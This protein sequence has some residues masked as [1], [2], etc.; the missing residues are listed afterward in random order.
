MNGRAPSASPETGPAAGVTLFAGQSAPPPDRH[1]V[2]QILRFARHARDNGFPVGIDESLDALRFAE[3]ADLMDQGEIRWGLRALFCASTADWERFDDLFDSFWIYRGQRT[4]VRVSGAA[5]R[6]GGDA[7]RPEAQRLGIE[8]GASGGDAGET[9]GGASAAE[10]LAGTDFRHLHDARDLEAVH[11][12]AERL[13]RRMRWRLSR[14]RRVRARGRVID[15]RNTIHK[16][17][18]HGGTPM[19]LAFKRRHPRPLKLVVILD[20]SG[21]MSLYSSFFVRFIRG[22]VESF[23]ESEAYVFHT[24]LVHLSAALREK[25]IER[26]VERMSMMSAGWGGGTR[27]GECLR[28]FN[29]HHAKSALNSRS[30]VMIVSDGYDTG[31]PELLAAQLKKLRGRAKRVIWLNPLLG[32]QGYEPVAQGMSAALPYV[33]LFAPAHN[34]ES[35]TALEPYLCKL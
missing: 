8:G 10:R 27:I 6:P 11:A 17:L 23:A 13:A 32:W 1:V 25:D 24:R 9:P 14:R 30:V 34:L 2:R 33:D 29:R 7:E 19:K 15:L 28:T 21:S 3:A 4:E 22:I 35:L 31:P 5:P 16:S 20:A 26:A 18:R 12:L